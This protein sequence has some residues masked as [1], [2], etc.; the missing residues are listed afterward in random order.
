MV[1]TPQPQ[2]RLAPAAAHL[3]K[4]RG[5]LA[6]AEVRDG[7]H[8]VA[9]KA[10]RRE[11]VHLSMGGK[12]RLAESGHEERGLAAHLADERHDGARRDDLIAELWRVA[13]DVS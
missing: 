6:A 12:V 3:V 9:H 4:R 13:G 10:Q 8:T 11:V 7:P 5:R 1:V 2:T